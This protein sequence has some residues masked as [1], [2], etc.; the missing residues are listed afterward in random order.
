M[1]EVP[2][3]GR[4]GII[5]ERI[6]I[7]EEEV[8]GEGN[9]ELRGGIRGG[10]TAASRKGK[11]GEKE[12]RGVIFVLSGWYLPECCRLSIIIQSLS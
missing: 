10:I 3:V 6:M 7:L 11:I 2:M 9:R 5:I 1:V 4:L 12:S 8:M